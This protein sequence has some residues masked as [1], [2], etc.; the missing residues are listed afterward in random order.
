MTHNFLRF[1][2]GKKFPELDS[3]VMQPT[4]YATC[5]KRIETSENKNSVVLNDI[6]SSH[7][8]VAVKIAMGQLKQAE[9]SAHDRGNCLKAADFVIYLN[10][11]KLKVKLG[12]LVH[13]VCGEQNEQ[14]GTESL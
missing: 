12:H 11:L 1:L 8:V 6:F 14:L 7:L 3:L 2:Y 9:L 10:D 4:Q 13:G 5:V